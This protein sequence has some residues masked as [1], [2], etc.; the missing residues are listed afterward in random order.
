MEVEV[1]VEYEY[2]YS[3]SR[4]PGSRSCLLYSKPLSRYSCTAGYNCTT[5]VYSWTPGPPRGQ[6]FFMDRESEGFPHSEWKLSFLLLR[7]CNCA[8]FLSRVL[9]TD[10]LAA[11]G[12][13]APTAVTVH[14][15]E[16]SVLLL[17]RIGDSCSCSRPV[18]ES[19]RL[20]SKPRVVRST[21]RAPRRALSTA[22]LGARLG[23]AGAVWGGRALKRGTRTIVVKSLGLTTTLGPQVTYSRLPHLGRPIGQHD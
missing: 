12:L 5:A 23:G 15:T 6:G 16:Y 17:C 7:G 1:P 19:P 4:A 14:S 22:Q 8:K 3:Y 13:L 20:L 2:M 18:P 10:L 9:A 11:V 21:G